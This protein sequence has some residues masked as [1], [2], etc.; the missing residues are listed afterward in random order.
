MLKD[1]GYSIAVIVSALSLAILILYRR[2]SVIP[3]FLISFV[4]LA[5]TVLM[6]VYWEGFRNLVLQIFDGTK[7]VRK[8]EDLLS[9]AEGDTADSF[10]NRI[11]RY[12]W[13]IQTCFRYPIIGGRLFNGQVGGH[14]EIL[15]TFARY[16][17][18]GGVPLLTII[19]HVPRYFKNRYPT[20]TVIATANAH[21][22]AIA[23]V[24]LFDPFVFQVFFPLLILCPIMYSDIYKWRKHS[25]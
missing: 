1:A 10:A 5:G 8:I 22:T 25:L 24:A 15:D 16:G 4:L 11:T 14:S 12:W 2:K 23:L 20:A 6:L 13:S 17:V 18:W 9:T 19:F 7:V 3:A 21:I